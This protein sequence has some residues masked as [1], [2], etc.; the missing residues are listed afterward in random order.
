MNSTFVFYLK[1]F[2]CKQGVEGGCIVERGNVRW[3]F[4][5]LDHLQ[6]GRRAGMGGGIKLSPR[7]QSAADVTEWNRN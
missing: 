5:D 3:E 4:R 7:R 1:L 6:R 2:A